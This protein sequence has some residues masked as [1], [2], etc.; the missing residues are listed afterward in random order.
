MAVHQDYG[1]RVQ[2]LLDKYNAEGKKVRF[3]TENK[4]E[5]RVTLRLTGENH[6]CSCNS[7]NNFILIFFQNVHVYMQGASSTGAVSSKIW[8]VEILSHCL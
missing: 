5:W 4:R 2:V 1:S 6:C 3:H 8:C 7:G